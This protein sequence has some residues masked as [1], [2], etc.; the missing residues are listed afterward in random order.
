MDK[1]CRHRK[2]WF[3]GGTV[4]LGPCELFSQCRIREKEFWLYRSWYPLFKDQMYGIQYVVTIIFVSL[5]FLGA[6]V[7]SVLGPSVA[8]Q[9][10]YIGVPG[11]YL[12]ASV[13]MFCMVIPCR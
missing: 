8:T 1:L 11:L 6:Q 5:D 12:L 13:I 2:L 4:F 3:H 9:A 10:D 7:G